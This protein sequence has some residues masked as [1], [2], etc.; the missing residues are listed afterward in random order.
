MVPGKRTGSWARKVMRERRAVVETR[1]R[2][3]LST[4]I[5]PEVGR[6]V[7]RRERAR[8]DLPEPWF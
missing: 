8:V 3:M 6:M 5:F 1:A 7:A 4:R 2:S